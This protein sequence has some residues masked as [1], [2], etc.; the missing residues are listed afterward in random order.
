MPSGTQALDRSL[1]I[2]NLFNKERLFLTLPEVAE[3]LGVSN[4]TA[5]RYVRA[6]VDTGLL[7]H[8]NGQIRLT[9]K[10]LRYSDLFLSDDHIVKAAREPME[11][12]F[13]KTQETI[14]LCELQG[15]TVTCTHR[16]ESHFPLRSS[17]QIGEARPIY[18][19]A[20]SRA[21]AAFL[22]QN[23]LR[24]IVT[25]TVWKR[26][27][28]NTVD[29][30]EEFYR[31]LDMVREREYDVSFEEVTQGVVALAVPLKWPPHSVASL[32]MTI[33]LARYSPKQLDLLL[34]PLVEARKSIE[35][36][37]REIAPERPSSETE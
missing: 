37:L 29:T 24:S 7:S 21:L 35:K 19:G 16:L 3:F 15:V 36:T 25:R 23:K 33:P 28:S 4:G 18:A 26:F 13:E 32:G 11:K 6:F 30:P 14:A 12:V 22:P 9:S 27:T 31:K 2:L 5:Y 8:E 17:F 1:A 20:F 34:Q 10:F